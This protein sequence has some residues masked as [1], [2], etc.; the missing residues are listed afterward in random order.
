MTKQKEKQRI[1]N[2]IDHGKKIK[3]HA[4]DIWGWS[5]PAGKKR[6]DR[7]AQYFIS[8]GNYTSDSNILEIGCGTSLF[9][10]KV[11]NIS[12]ANITAIDI[13]ED[14]L[15]KA[16][17]K[18]PNVTFQ[19]ED[20]M[21][22][23]FKNGNFDSVWGSSVLHHLDIEQALKEIYRVLKPGGSMVFAEPN[24]LNPQ[25]FIQKSVP[26]IKRLMGDSPDETAFVRWKLKKTLKRIGFKDIN[27]FP[28]DFL[29]PATP[30]K[31]MRFISNM[32]LAFEKTP[33]MKEIAGSLIIYAKKSQ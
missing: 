16:K 13:S 29:H 2:E 23:S 11:F 33:I 25:I 4:E 32:G 21:K 27:I 17:Q 15:E 1:K 31:M 3:E 7:R 12:Q 24:M 18:L 14:L 19:K 30:P 26:F 20:A 22:M 6:A 10:E 9:T 8:L 5:T 28:Y